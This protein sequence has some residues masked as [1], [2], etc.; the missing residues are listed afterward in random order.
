LSQQVQPGTRAP[1]PGDL[2]VV[3]QFINSADL[4]EGTD[5]LTSTAGLSLWLYEHKLTE[6]RLRLAPAD[7]QRARRVREML[8]S[9]ALANNGFP[10]RDS[11]A[12]AINQEFSRLPLL[13]RVTPGRAMRIESGAHGLDRALGR[14][15]AIVVAEAVSGRWSRLKACPRDICHWAFYDHS[16][17]RTGTW[18]TMAVCGSRVK[19]QAY[20]RRQVKKDRD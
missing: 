11:D 18:C 14:I 6:R 1:A 15:L 19:A 12:R 9:L 3:Q 8:R 20:Y 4:E 7:V 16:R 17:S 13:A 10:L 5:R 2:K